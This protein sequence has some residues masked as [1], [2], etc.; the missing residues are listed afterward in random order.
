[1]LASMRR[2]EIIAPR[3][4]AAA[5]LRSVHRAGVVHLTTFEP[6]HGGGVFSL[7][8]AGPRDPRPAP[9]SS[10]SSSGSLGALTELLGRPGASDKLVAELW[11]LDDAALQARAATLDQVGARAS[12][13]AGE[14]QRLRGDAARLAGYRQI[15]EGLRRAIGHLPSVRGYGSTGIVV[16]SRYREVVGLI[17]EELES[18]TDGR[19]EVLS[20]DID[21]DRVAA[22]LIYPL[23][24]AAE[25]RTIVGG[26]DLEEVTL[27]ES[28]AAVPFDELAPRL[29][30]EEATI[31][32][33]EAEVDAELD[34]LASAHGPLVGALGLVLGD[35]AAEARVIDEA[36]RSDHL[37]V[38]AGWVPADGVEGLRARLAT[39]VGPEVV[40]VER[41]TDPSEPSTPVAFRN[42][43]VVRAFEPLSS[44]VSL[45]HSGTVDPT[46]VVA[47][48]VPL[49]V[50]LMVG[51]AGYGMVL[52]AML[53]GARRR[54]RHVPAVVAIWPVGALV[55]ISTIGFGLL[56][57]EWFGDAGH[58]LF[59]LEPLWFDRREAVTSM[60]LL[61]LAIGVAQIGFGLVLGVVNA[62]R[63][64][65]RRE[66]FG[67]AALLG[68]LV[69][70]IA[71]L[72]AAAGFLPASVGQLGVVAVLSGLVILA[73]TLG[74]GGPLEMMSV[75]G[76]VLSYARLMAIGLASVMLALIANRM[77]GLV[78]SVLVGFVIAAIFHVLA[79][80]LGFFDASVQGLRLQYV[81]FFSKFAE[82]SGV[83]YEPFVSVLG[84]RDRALGPGT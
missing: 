83:R 73:A 79:F 65:H 80:V 24:Q 82:P 9:A 11:P 15:I 59:G 51:D 45:P 5:V 26:R 49:F 44:F 20:A 48:V 10:P 29:E 19:C 39:E 61:A 8:Q 33:R 17:R 27:P 67:R 42:W 70:M 71:T 34:Q 75:V 16:R 55:A 78:E 81:E 41:E 18:L 40:L 28:L 38:V 47:F 2:I 64:R 56:F 43:R 72:A 37:V 6:P 4:S 31:R 30:A 12:T 57:G 52:L 69:A 74:L 46:P 32:S 14:R 53:A 25:V 63:L 13:L 77:G 35:R 22:V 50:G 68:S 58:S 1:M 23:R 54:W 66:A 21:A 84:A 60:L 76:N 36:G 7:G 62:T 3:T